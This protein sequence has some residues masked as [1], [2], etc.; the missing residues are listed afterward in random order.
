MIRQTLDIISRGE[1]TKKAEVNNK[2]DTKWIDTLNAVLEKEDNVSDLLHI[3][4][5]CEE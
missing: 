2:E 1:D 5:G 4:T 3:Q